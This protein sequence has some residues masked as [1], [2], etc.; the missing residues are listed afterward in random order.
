M[1][2]QC[3][4]MSEDTPLY[5]YVGQKLE[6]ATQPNANQQDATV[7]VEQLLQTPAPLS[8][9]SIE[10][11]HHFY[12]MTSIDEYSK[13]VLNYAVEWEQVVCSRLDREIKQVAF[14][15]KRKIHYERKVNGLRSKV[16]HLDKNGREVTQ[17]LSEKLARNEEKLSTAWATHEK[18]SAQLCILLEECVQNG[19]KD[20]YTFVKN[21]SRFEINKASRGEV[22]KMKLK[23]NLVA[24]KASDLDAMSAPS[25]EL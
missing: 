24:M 2:R 14:L 15:Q 11:L 19:F 12:S 18:M 3:A 4:K 17:N 13:Y 6:D 16:N 9:A 20:L 8:L 5:E 7:H 10:D 25:N 23:L 21:W 1:M 22:L